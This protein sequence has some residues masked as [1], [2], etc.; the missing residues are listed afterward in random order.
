MYWRE[1]T[2][3]GPPAGDTERD[4]EGVPGSLDGTGVVGDVLWVFK[5]DRIYKCKEKRVWD[6]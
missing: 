4:V 1:T 5:H 6:E 3:K 2:L